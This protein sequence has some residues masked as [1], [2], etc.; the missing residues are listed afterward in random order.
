MCCDRPDTC[1]THL[2]HLLCLDID[3]QQSALEGLG[4][5]DVLIPDVDCR[6][7]HAVLR[8]HPLTFRAHFLLGRTNREQRGWWEAQRRAMEGGKG[9]QDLMVRHR[10]AVWYIYLFIH[11]QWLGLGS[12]PKWWLIYRIIGII[13]WWFDQIMVSFYIMLFKISF[14]T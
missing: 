13:L 6:G 4:H 2:H 3:N 12:N 9:W 10:S 5:V 7:P 11:H 8:W 14:S 1:S